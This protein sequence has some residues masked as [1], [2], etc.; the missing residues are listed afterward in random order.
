[1][2]GFLYF[3]KWEEKTMIKI[4]GQH[5]KHEWLTKLMKSDMVTGS[6]ALVRSLLIEGVENVFGIP[7]GSVLNIFTA[8]R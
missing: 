1:M 2:E 8:M 4:E 3:R 7:G 6:E 5:S